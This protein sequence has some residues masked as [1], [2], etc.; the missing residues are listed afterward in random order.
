MTTF[1]YKKSSSFSKAHTI[2]N[3]DAQSKHQQFIN[4]ALSTH[5]CYDDIFSVIFVKN[6]PPVL[7]LAERQFAMVSRQ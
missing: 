7:A 1:F 3:I 4:P 5:R 6:K 2:A